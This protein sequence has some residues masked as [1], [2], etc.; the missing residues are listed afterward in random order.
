MRPALA[1]LERDLLPDAFIRFGIRGLLRRRLADET[2]GG[3]A[4]V[5]RRKKLLVVKLRDSPIAL[6]TGDANEQHYEVPTDFFRHAI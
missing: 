3:A 5:E 2:Q 1:L 6:H 4:A